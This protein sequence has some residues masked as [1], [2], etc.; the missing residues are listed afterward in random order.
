[1]IITLDPDPIQ[2]HPVP[3]TAPADLPVIVIPAHD[4]GTVIAGCLRTLLADA[5]AED[6]RVVVVC[7]GCSD[8]TAG[9]AHAAAAA[10]PVRVDVLEID[11]ASKA[12][13]LRAGEESGAGFPRIYLD[14]DVGCST[15]TVRAL[16]AALADGA[17]VAVPSRVLELGDAGFLARAY[18]TSWAQLPWVQAQL[19]GRGAYALSE[20]ARATF[21]AFPD[22]VADD[23]YATSRVPR[24]RAVVVEEPVVIRPPCRLIDVV[25][26][27][28]RIYAGNLATDAPTHDATRSERTRIL[29]GLVTRP[30]LWPGLAVFIATTIVAKASAMHAIGQGNLT[31]SRDGQRAI[32]AGP[33]HDNRHCGARHP[34]TGER[35]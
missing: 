19:A 10:S 4:E 32:P 7:N 28:S 27:R 34:A 2:S 16:I 21:A 22:V 5:T 15:A 17:D 3:S 29:G 13:A 14:A 26:V 9:R 23:R 35:E 1:M 31:W 20:R 25:R 18:Y 8:D 11:V 30:S 33:N 24:D 12:A 6:F